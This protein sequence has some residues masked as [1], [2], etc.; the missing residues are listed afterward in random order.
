VGAAVGGWLAQHVGAAAVFGFGVALTAIWLAI[1]A[2]MA[3]PPAYPS[4]YSLGET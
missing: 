1:G 3:A 2:T 4:N